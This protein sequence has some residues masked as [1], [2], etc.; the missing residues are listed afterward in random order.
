M[1]YMRIIFGSLKNHI[2]A[3][4]PWLYVHIASENLGRPLGTLDPPLGT[5]DP[6]I[7]G[8]TAGPFE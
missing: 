8:F 3:A 6:D 4:L 1:G 2:L 7:C 5:L